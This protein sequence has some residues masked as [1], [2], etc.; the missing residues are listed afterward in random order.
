MPSEN[1]VREWVTKDAD[2]FAAQYASAR[3]AGYHAMAEEILEIA[4]D[5]TRDTILSEHGARP[6]SEWIGRSKLRVDSRKWLLSKMLPKVYGDTQKID[7]SNTDGTLQLTEAARAARVAE[8]MAIAQARVTA[9]DGS[10][11]S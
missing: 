7:L 1:A 2:G 5:T 11:L 6:N 4:D 3:E 8:L 10:E 9:G